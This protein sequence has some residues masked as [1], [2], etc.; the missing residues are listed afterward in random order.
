MLAGLVMVKLRRTQILL[1]FHKVLAVFASSPMAARPDFQSAAAN[2]GDSQLAAGLVSVYFTVYCAS[3]DA[4]R[5]FLYRVSSLPKKRYVFP[6]TLIK[7]SRE[8]SAPVQ[9]VVVEPARSSV[10]D[11][12][13]KLGLCVI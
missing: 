7:P 3:S 9:C 11:Q 12:M 6:S 2:R 5:T 13:L 1:D 8:C 4:E 10:F